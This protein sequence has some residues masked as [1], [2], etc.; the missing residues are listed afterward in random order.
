MRLSVLD[1]SPIPEG[2]TAG[3]ALRHSLQ[4]AQLTDRLGYTRYWVA[5]HHGTRGLACNSPEVLIGP[6][7]AAT[8]RIRVGSGGIMLPHY[9]PLKVAE[10][11]SMLTGLYPGRIDLGIGRAAGTSPKVAF[12]LQRDRRQA[13]PDDFREQ[14][15]ELITYLANRTPYRFDSPE[16]SLLGSSPDSSLW[17]AELGLPYVFADFINPNGARVARYYRQTFTPS[18]LLPAPRTSVAVWAICADT[19]EEAERL[20]LSFRMM[21]TLLFRGKS[22]AVPAIE[23]A[24]RFLE[25]EGLM[26]D[27][28]PVGRRI[29]TGTPVRVREAIEQ[30]ACD[31]EADEVLIVNILHSHEAR[32][33]SYEL[34]AREFGI[35]N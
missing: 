25:E 23:T 29:V 15:D 7:A 34:I 26:P 33:R 30:V 32:L 22:V 21:M 24:Q 31:Y 19:D 18:D 13:A 20:S 28:A 11:F 12:A 17:A 8:S 16:L 4:L 2:S 9:S 5:E 6:I 1:Q 14:L 35:D 3:D 10:S 27:Q